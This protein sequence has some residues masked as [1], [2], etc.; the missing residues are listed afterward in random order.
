[1]HLISLAVGAMLTASSLACGV[2][3]EDRVA[4][5]YD[6]NIVMTAIAKHHLVVFG[7]IEGVVDMQAAT[8]K[9][10]ATAPRV[11]GV[12]RSTVRTSVSP[13]AVSV[14]LDPGVQAPAAALGAIQKRVRMQGVKLSILRVVSSESLQQAPKRRAAT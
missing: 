11:R 14:A 10:A 1:M 9:I 13:P 2:C 6:Y 4:A 12:D 8:A 7:Q 3:I 5:T